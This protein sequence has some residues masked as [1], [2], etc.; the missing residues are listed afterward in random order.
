MRL[1]YFDDFIVVMFDQ[2]YFPKKESK[3]EVFSFICA[4]KNEINFFF[5]INF[6]ENVKILFKF[7]EFYNAIVFSVICGCFY[8][9][10]HIV[11]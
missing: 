10:P 5:F 6:N 4:K 3:P 2:D 11:V 7:S 1:N 9:I 8:T